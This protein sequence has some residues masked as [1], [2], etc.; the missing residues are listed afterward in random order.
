MDAQEIAKLCENLS[1]KDKVGPLM[2]LQTGLKDDGEK[3]LALLLAS[4]IKS[5]KLVNREAFINLIPRIWRLRYGVDIEV[6]EGN[7]F[8]F[9]FKDETNR[10]QVLQGGPW[11]FD[12]A[13]PVLEEPTGKGDIREMRF[14]QVAFWIQIHN[15][16]LLCMTTEIGRFLGSMIGVVKEINDMT[17]D[18]AG[19]YIRVRVVVNVDQPLHR[20]LRVDVLRD[21]K[22]DCL[23][24]S[25][26]DEPKDF[27]LLFGPWLNASSPVKLMGSQRDNDGKGKAVL[28]SAIEKLSSIAHLER[29]DLAQ[30]SKK[31][32][33]QLRKNTKGMNPVRRNLSFVFGERGKTE[34]GR[35]TDP[36]YQGLD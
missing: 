24:K 31:I 34:S 8:S 29:K 36:N 27:N 26:S 17:G 20:I 14:N 18:Y 9:T 2:P 19:K 22:E 33:D 7:T 6:I 3:R 4:R 30:S 21:G 10:Y 15:V 28:M 23:S 35:E 32:P 16:P 13:L 5:N 1:L 11:S 25:T 12:K